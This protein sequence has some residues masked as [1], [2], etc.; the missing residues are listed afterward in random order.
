MAIPLAL[1]LQN[2]QLGLGKKTPFALSQIKISQLQLAN[3][4]TRQRRTVIARSGQHAFHLVVFALLEH[5]FNLEFAQLARTQRRN[6]RGLI[7]Q[8]HAFQ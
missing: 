3:R 6:W 7:D 8:L 1:P 5:D 2:R 4:G